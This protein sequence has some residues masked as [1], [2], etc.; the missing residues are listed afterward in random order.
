MCLYSTTCME[1]D[2][3]KD[4]NNNNNKYSVV[5]VVLIGS[6]SCRIRWRWEPLVSVSHSKILP[7]DWIE[8]DQGWLSSGHCTIRLTRSAP[9]SWTSLF[10][11]FISTITDGPRWYGHLVSHRRLLCEILTRVYSAKLFCRLLLL[12]VWVLVLWEDR[13]FFS[14]RLL[15]F[16]FNDIKVDILRTLRTRKKHSIFLA[17]SYVNLLKIKANG[18]LFSNVKFRCFCAK[19][20]ILE[21]QKI[22]CLYVCL[23]W[24]SFQ[25]YRY[26]CNFLST[27]F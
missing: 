5:L 6:Y 4:N 24:I 18:A 21:K 14:T 23:L 11:F 13:T 22:A 9:F 7:V 12:M 26:N 8:Y 17:H 27:Y 2:S 25:S 1:N 3:L 19:Y 10:L 20:L 16:V 15:H